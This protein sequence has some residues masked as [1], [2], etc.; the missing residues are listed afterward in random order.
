MKPKSALNL[1]LAI[2]LLL[3]LTSLVYAL[4]C[5]CARCGYGGACQKVCRLVCEDK[6][7]EVTC[8]GSVCEDFCI[9][10]HGIRGCEHCEM[11]CGECDCNPDTPNAKAKPFVWTDWMPTKAVMFT[12]HKL[13]K[14]T[15]TKNVPSYK[16]VV[17]DL[18]P[19]CEANCPCASIEPG[20]ELPPVPPV[21]G[22]SLKYHLAEEPTTTEVK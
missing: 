4:E 10:C 6:K 15:I 5:R 1:L 20:T 2:S 13:M 21:P 12:R 14:K 8:W 22:A 7:I 16:W 11:V 9:P 17:E 18:C 19:Q 3:C